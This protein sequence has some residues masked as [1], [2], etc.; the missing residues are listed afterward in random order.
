MFDSGIG[1]AD[2]D[3]IFITTTETK[4]RHES[5]RIRHAVKN[6][7]VDRHRI[8]V[9]GGTVD[10]RQHSMTVVRFGAGVGELDNLYVARERVNALVTGDCAT[11]PG[12]DEFFLQSLARTKGDLSERDRVGLHVL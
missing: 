12:R 6:T 10:S 9:N 2:H 11:V 4:L 7:H 3:A 5:E 1:E 8:T